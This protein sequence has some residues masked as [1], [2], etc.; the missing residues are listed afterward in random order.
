M[1]SDEAD[2]RRSGASL[3]VAI[4]IAV[5]LYTQ[6]PQFRDFIDRSRDWIQSKTEQPAEGAFG[7]P[8]GVRFQNPSV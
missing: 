4:V 6:V 3:F 7:P 8:T 1:G 2:D 5:V